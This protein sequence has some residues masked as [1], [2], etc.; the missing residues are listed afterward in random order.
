MGCR[1]RY[2]KYTGQNTCRNLRRNVIFTDI[3]RK[4]N[5]VH[6]S[7]ILNRGYEEQTEPW[8][9]RRSTSSDRSEFGLWRYGTQHLLWITPRRNKKEIH[10]VLGIDLLRP[11]DSY[12]RQQTSHL[13]FGQ[14][15]VVWSARSYYP[16]QCW[17]IFNSNLMNNFQWNLKWNLYIFIQENAFENV[18]CKM[19]AV[20]SRPKWV[21]RLLVYVYE[22]ACVIKHTVFSSYTG[23][24]SLSLD[25][26]QHA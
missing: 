15:L 18:V 8:K 22:Y 9:W 16:N 24:H 1:V 25:W 11:S 21:N 5:T 17:N 14:R 13:W 6:D 4:N 10:E 19:A 2:G 12:I 26:I 23:M 7:H 3:C 20:L